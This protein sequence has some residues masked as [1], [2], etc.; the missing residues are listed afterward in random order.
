MIFP[1]ALYAFLISIFGPT[2][3]CEDLINRPYYSS[4][5]QELRSEK[6]FMIARPMEL[7]DGSYATK[8]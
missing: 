4:P 7:I 8:K 3:P 6:D 1:Q 2:F 5:A